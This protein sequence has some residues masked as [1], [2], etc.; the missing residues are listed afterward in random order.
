MHEAEF[1][2]NLAMVMMVAGLVTVLFRLAKQPVVLGYIL[3]GWL[4]GPN[5]LLPV[6][7]IEN[8]A[9]IH[10][11][12]EIGI[13]FLL[14]SL[15]LEFNLR[16]I[17]QIGPT[18]FLVAPLE[19]GIMFFLGLQLGRLMGWETMDCVYLG[20]IMMISSTTI[21]TKTLSEMRLHREKFADVIFGILIAE[22]I[23]AILMIA[24]LS[25]VGLTGEFA[26]VP[27]LSTIG[28]LG[29]FLITLLVVG[30]LLVPRLLDY[31]GKFRSEETLLIAALGLCFGVSL[32]AIK[33]E[34]S[35]ALGAFII[36]AVIAESHEIDLIERLIGPIKIMFSAVFFTAIGLMIDPMKIWQYIGPILLISAAIM[37]GKFIFC[38]FGSFI[39]GYDQKTSLKVGMGMSQIG[40]FSFIIAALGMNMGVISDHVYPIAVAVSAVTSTCTPYWIRLSDRAVD[41]HAK[42]APK[43]WLNY[44][45]TYSSWIQRLSRR[46][47]D[48]AIKKMIR[49]ILIQLLV[50]IS[51]IG[52]IFLFAAIIYRNGVSW[53]NWFPEKMGGPGAALWGI[54]LVASLPVFIAYYRKLQAFGMIL[55]ELAAPQRAQR[56]VRIASKALIAN[57]VLFTGLIII[58]FMI[59]LLSSAFLPPAEILT[60]LAVMGVVLALV[61]R[62]F[63]IR[64]YAKAQIALKE[65]LTKEKIKKHRH[66]YD[67]EDENHQGGSK[68]E[69]PFDHAAIQT[70]LISTLNPFIGMAIR[71]TKLRSDTGCSVIAVRRA[72]HTVLSPPPEWIFESEDEAMLLGSPEQL[73]LG[74][75]LIET[76]GKEEK[77]FSV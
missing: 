34:Y 71:D 2:Q 4:L 14:F 72:N 58:V 29:A 43:I 45:N 3:A 61:L 22:D 59:L 15:G 46:K 57:T 52:G 69:L 42:F 27:I 50:N 31:I 60:A 36:G 35:V 20:A 6:H 12:G 25:G 10:T 30:L 33:L 38:S 62:R 66:S 67:S 13:V 63:F 75:K 47:K 19:T 76:G 8:E 1:L 64:I 23:I 41:A 51:L 65:T 55:S 73:L 48:S 54:S 11:L 24:A 56:S 37:T 40:E 74:R 21:I 5:T 49:T 9:I 68:P 26:W 44:L 28:K 77:E 32:L 70:V 18:V 17:R 39:G 16:K 7:L 53:L